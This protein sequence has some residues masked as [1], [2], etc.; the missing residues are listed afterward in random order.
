MISLTIFQNLPGLPTAMTMRVLIA[1]DKF[2]DALSASEA[3]AIASSAL[4][5]KY[6]DWEL[7]LCPLADGGEGLT[8]A[9]VQAS[10][11]KV[12]RRRAT[13]PRGIST[14]AKMG[15]VT[16][17][18]IS[19]PAR[20]KI[21]AAIGSLCDDAKVAVIEM[22][23][24]S[25]LALLRPG[26]RDPWWTTS[27]GTGELMRAA[28][29][30]DVS[31]ILLGVGG[32]ATNDLGFGALAALGLSFQDISGAS[33]PV[34]C[35]A[36]WHSIRTIYGQVDLPPVLIL[37]D[38]RNPLL[39]SEGA[40]ATFSLQKGARTEDRWLL[41]SRTESMATSL[42]NAF[43][44][45]ISIAEVSGAGAGGG[46]AFGLMV[47]AGAKLVPGFDLV[48]NWL[49][50]PSRI[51]AADLI[52]TGE[53]RFDATSLSGKGPGSLMMEARRA[54]KPV[55][56]FAGSV[57]LPNQTGL[58]AIAPSWLPLG[59]ALQR[60]PELLRAAILECL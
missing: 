51:L 3:C 35:P 9:L 24:A 59:K 49:N 36:T 17:S 29:L 57:G 52:L 2:K 60:T 48:A 8:D 4:S 19:M 33:I 46:I 16:W 26:L 50:L 23:S 27:L 10:G 56:V 5:E 21:S 13:G 20:G 6:P 12:I 53:G 1:F 38:V 31:A 41:E 7:D 22:A 37:C 55:E 39:G 11:G 34:P 54:G 30:A 40:V 43:S 25:G 42:C 44:Q 15:L 14:E 28:S 32:S 47:A 58:N 45:P 18:D